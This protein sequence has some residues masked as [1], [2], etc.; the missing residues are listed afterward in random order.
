MKVLIGYDGSAS[1]EAA[2]EELKRAGLPADT[3]ILV[4]TVASI[5]TPPTE[6]ASLPGAALTSR[7]LTATMAQLQ[8]QAERTLNEAEETAG[9]AA[10]RIKS[11][12]PEWQVGT[13]ILSGDAA[14][15][16]IRQ[17]AAWHA[18][19]IV[20]G[21]QNRSA[22]GRFFLGS[23]SQKVFIEADCSVRIARSETTIDKDASRRIVAGI[24]DSESA[25]LIVDA[26]AE[27]NWTANSAVK[28]VT[29]TD[30][31]RENS[32][33][34]FKEFIKTQDF[35]N[36]AREKLAASGLKVSAA[37]N[38]GEASNELLVEAE[39]WN[40]DCIFVGTRDIRGILDRFLIGSV[41]AGLAANAP[42]SV[43]VVRAHA[44]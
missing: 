1:A 10:A 44:V 30:I 37:V 23:V 41:S 38:V 24:D 12:F 32:V 22:I 39:K 4:A 20:T 6:I 34:P 3:K 19:L 25:D 21:S 11:D 43:E 2:L 42:C 14:F 29:A 18:D 35:H 16:I 40:A 15:E 9:E 33:S 26:I 27:R 8:N 36:Q 17:A 7:R 28:L 31:F 13:T 5:W